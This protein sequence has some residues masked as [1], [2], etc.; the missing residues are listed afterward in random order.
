MMLASG[1]AYD[2]MNEGMPSQDIDTLADDA[3][4]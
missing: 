3:E 2:L 1:L 4:K